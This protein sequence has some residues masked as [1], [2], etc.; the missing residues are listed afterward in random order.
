MNKEEKERQ[1]TIEVLLSILAISVIIIA[2]LSLTGTHFYKK[3]V[4][5]ER[6]IEVRSCTTIRDVL[7]YGVKVYCDVTSTGFCYNGNMGD[8]DGQ[9]FYG[10][11][12]NTVGDHKSN[13]LRICGFGS[14]TISYK[15]KTISIKSELF[16]SP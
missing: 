4:W 14:C 2:V 1:Q 15:T 16:G 6:N 7:D 5:K 10:P 11:L 13:D 12:S 9:V 3:E 8:C